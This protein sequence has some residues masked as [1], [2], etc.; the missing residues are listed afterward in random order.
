LF[1]LLKLKDETI[2]DLKG[3]RPCSE[4]VEPIKSCFI[5]SSSQLKK[6]R[7]NF[8]DEYT[9]LASKKQGIL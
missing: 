6:N 7:E 1:S 4:P 3:L 5:H 2:N 8:L 9:I